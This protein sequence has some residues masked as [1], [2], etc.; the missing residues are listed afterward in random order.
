[1]G[2]GAGRVDMS[3]KVRKRRPDHTCDACC[4]AYLAHDEFVQLHAVREAPTFLYRISK[5]ILSCRGT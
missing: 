3:A 2:C 4:V 5:V 1:M